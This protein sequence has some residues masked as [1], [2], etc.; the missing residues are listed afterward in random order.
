MNSVNMLAGMEI[1]QLCPLHVNSFIIAGEGPIPCRYLILGEAPGKDETVD[2]RPFIGAAG[3]KLFDYVAMMGL[4]RDDVYVTN[5]NK[6]WTGLG[7][8]TPKKDEIKACRPWLDI[9]IEMVDPE[10]IICLGKTAIENIVGPTN[11]LKFHGLVI[12]R[13]VVGKIRKVAI[14]YHPAAGLHNPELL[15]VTANDFANLPSRISN[16][17]HAPDVEVLWND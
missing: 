1:C 9:E 13:E 4:T 3:K 16:P 15:S 14:M 11:L 5:G 7:N 12:E 10:V 8:P 17:V 6:H 2:L